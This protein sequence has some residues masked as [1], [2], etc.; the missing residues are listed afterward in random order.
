MVGRH[1]Q[2]QPG[3]LL[4]ERDH[5]GDIGTDGVVGE[6][7]IPH[8]AV[9]QHLDFRNR[10]GLVPA[11]PR[12]EQQPDDGGHL[13]GLAMRPQAIGRPGDLQH[14]RK[15]P[16]DER[17]E[18]NER[19]RKQVLRTANEIIVGHDRSRVRALTVLTRVLYND[20]GR[21]PSAGPTVAQLQQGI[22]Q[23]GRTQR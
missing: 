19:R 3:K 5:A 18:N 11:D 6:N 22:S 4:F 12:I 8:P 9:R 2:T 7:D 21:I 1:P 14:C 13:V 23:I 15:V 10:R 20:R 17:L 16:L